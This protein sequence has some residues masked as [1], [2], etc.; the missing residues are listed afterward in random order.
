MTNLIEQLRKQAKRRSENFGD[1]ENTLEWQAA[2]AIER[3]EAENARLQDF[4]TLISAAVAVCRDINDSG[5]EYS[6]PNADG[7][8]AL[9][10]LFDMIDASDV[11][12]T[13]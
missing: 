5:E 9:A 3:L 1:P 13:P 10:N 11:E 7:A 12:E 6:H 4:S 8:Q 2:D